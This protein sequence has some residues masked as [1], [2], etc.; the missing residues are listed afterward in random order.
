MIMCNK[1]ME[2]TLDVLC[3]Y[4]FEKNSYLDDKDKI[5]QEKDKEI[6]SLKGQLE[7]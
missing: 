1:K 7:V 6:V 4:V 3:Q 5:I 2:N